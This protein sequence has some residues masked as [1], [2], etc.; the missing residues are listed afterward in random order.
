MSDDVVRVA[1]P[2]RGA[3]KT[4]DMRHDVAVYRAAGEAHARIEAAGG[5]VD[6][7]GPPLGL[8]RKEG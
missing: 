3:V 7:C 2:D 4:A 6:R 1:P 8:R 5:R